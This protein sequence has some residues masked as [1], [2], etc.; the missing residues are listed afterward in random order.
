MLLGRIVVVVV[1]LAMIPGLGEVAE[2]A[3][4]LVETGHVTHVSHAHPDGELP[5]D[6]E[7]GCSGTFHLCTCCARPAFQM[8]ARLAVPPCSDPGQTSPIYESR[9]VTEPHVRGLLR[10]P[11]SARA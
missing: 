10:P 2:A 7:H 9:P 4:H 8:T 1:A 11:R 3:V 6:A 5:R